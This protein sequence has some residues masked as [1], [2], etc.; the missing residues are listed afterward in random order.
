LDR[1]VQPCTEPKSGPSRPLNRCAKEPDK[2]PEIGAEPDKNCKTDQN[3]I[4][5]DLDLVFRFRIL[6]AIRFIRRR[7]R[8]RKKIRR[9][10]KD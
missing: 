8:R 10:K 6:Q 4:D 1:P 2:K 7:R 9:M 3:K 5:L